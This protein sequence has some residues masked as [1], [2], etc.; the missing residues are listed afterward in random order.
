M[1][2][3]TPLAALTAL[4]ALLPVGAVLLGQRR[5]AAVRTLL[6]LTPPGRRASIV[7]V[8]IASAGIAVLGLAAA[9]PALTRKAN[10]QVRKDVG[11]LFVIDTSRSMAASATPTSPTRLDRAADAAVRLRLAIPTVASGLATLT[12]RVLPDLLPVAD[13]DAFAA[14]ARRSVQIESPPPR[15]FSTR[16]T[17]FSALSDVTAGNYFVPG[18]SKRIVVLLT[19]GESNPVD[20]SSLASDFG[21][22]GKYRFV[23]VHV[24]SPKESVFDSDGTAERAYQ[25]DPTSADVLDNLAGSLSGRS[26]QARNLGAATAYLKKLAGSGPTAAS[27]ARIHRTIALTPYFALIG[28]LLVVLAVLPGQLAPRSVRSFTR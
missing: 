26:F 25:P 13:S 17:T 9:Q 19:D 16:A 15:S 6:G 2:L 21:P 24:W 4:F 7:R 10:A 28:L 3:L 5:V 22:R 27:P 12:D 1:S 23:A 18:T 14:V 20:V 11:A 8:V